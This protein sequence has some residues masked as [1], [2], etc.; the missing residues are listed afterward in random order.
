MPFQIDIEGGEFA[1][2]GFNNWIESQVLKN[3]DQI[4]L[5]LHMNRENDP[6]LSF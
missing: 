5:E 3:V 6:R 1:T 4:A 2:G